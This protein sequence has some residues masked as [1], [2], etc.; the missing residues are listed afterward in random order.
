[1]SG[2]S[3]LNGSAPPDQSVP[4]PGQGD[5]LIDADRHS[6][7]NATA[8]VDNGI[9]GSG[10][11]PSMPDDQLPDLDMSPMGAQPVTPSHPPYE[12]QT[13]VSDP[14]SVATSPNVNKHA[15]IATHV[16]SPVVAGTT[17]LNNAG[18]DT[19]VA[20]APP[21]VPLEPS[22]YPLPAAVHGKRAMISKQA[23][24]FE[25]QKSQKTAAHESAPPLQLKN[26]PS[27]YQVC[28]FWVSERSYLKICIR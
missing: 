28:I 25:N 27:P 16:A 2:N 6:V 18:Q 8:Q 4:P 15:E 11:T 9:L 21:A 1:M 20:P 3:D 26:A 10:A 5:P 13:T 12:P 17:T 19:P 7:D 24:Q 14:H 22:T 23:H